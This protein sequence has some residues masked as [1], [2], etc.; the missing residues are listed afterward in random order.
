MFLQVIR[1][2]KLC[3][4]IASI[5]PAGHISVTD[6][7]FIG[8]SLLLFFNCQKLVIFWGG[9]NSILSYE[10]SL[11]IRIKIW[12][13]YFKDLPVFFPMKPCNAW[14]WNAHLYGLSVNSEYIFY[15]VSYTTIWKFVYSF[16]FIAIY[17]MSKFSRK[18][19]FRWYGPLPIPTLL[20]RF[21]FQVRARA[22]FLTRGHFIK[23]V[24]VIE[25][26]DYFKWS[27]CFK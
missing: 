2:P 11:S 19:R 9:P 10:V 12:L 8:V 22:L 25:L 13:V 16:S 5:L 4:S 26:F 21:Q 24:P 14:H 18:L 27:W 6:L 23:Q 7:P 17:S 1:L 20:F 15:S 3:S